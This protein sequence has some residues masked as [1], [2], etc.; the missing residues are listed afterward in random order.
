M[1]AKKQS[2]EH[3]VFGRAVKEF[4]ARRDLSQ[5]QF[6]RQASLHRNYVGAIERG[7]INP[8]LR[9]MLKIARGLEAPLSE[10]IVLFEARRDEAVPEL[11]RRT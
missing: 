3:V 7:E 2:D 6:G 5:E 8:T 10:L 1:A 11:R 9:V 4:R